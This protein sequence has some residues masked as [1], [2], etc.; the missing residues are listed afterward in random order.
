MLIKST[1]NH[2]TLM[3]Y[4][5]LSLTIFF[6]SAGGGAGAGTDRRGAPHSD[7]RKGR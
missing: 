2:Y 7:H 6:M 5:V 4:Q 3:V 1:I